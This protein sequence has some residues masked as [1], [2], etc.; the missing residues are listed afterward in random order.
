MQ[1]L[2]CLKMIKVRLKGCTFSLL[3]LYIGGRGYRV[4]NL[5]LLSRERGGGAGG[6]GELCVQEH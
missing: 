6:H 5:L 3:D 2:Y 1:K 4:I